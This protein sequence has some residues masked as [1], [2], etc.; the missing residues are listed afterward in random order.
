MRLIAWCEVESWWWWAE[1]VN[2][3]QLCTTPMVQSIGTSQTQWWYST[4]S[5]SPTLLSCYRPTHC[6]NS[7][8]LLCEDQHLH[9]NR[10][11]VFSV[12]GQQ[13][14]TFNKPIV[15]RRGSPFFCIMTV[16]TTYLKGLFSSANRLMQVS[17]QVDVHCPT[18][19]SLLSQQWSAWHKMCSTPLMVTHF[20]VIVLLILQDGVYRLL[21]DARHILCH[22]CRLHTEA[23]QLVSD[24]LVVERSF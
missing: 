15:S 6:P 21:D 14:H 1:N 24:Q 11:W 19:R 2:A 4:W 7:K 9:S 16:V 3:Q 17:R 12:S 5:C 13:A 23:C 8:K 18:C 20:E 10:L 22:E